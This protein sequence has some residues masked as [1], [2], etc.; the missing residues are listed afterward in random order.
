MGGIVSPDLDKKVAGLCLLVV[1]SV[2]LTLRLYGI[3]WDEGFDW[4][5]HPDERAILS[6]VDS[7]APP[8]I[9]DLRVLLDANESPWNPR[10]FPYGS[11]PLYLLKAVKLTHGLLPGTDLTDL[12]VA[13]RM[14]S[15]LADVATVAVVFAVGSAAYSRRVGLVAAALVA[16]A[17]IHIQL[18]HF[19]AADT[20]LALFAVLTMYYLVRVARHGRL[21]DSALAGLFVGLGLATKISLAPILGPFVVAHLM[22]GLGPLMGSS[23]RSVLLT[24]KVET[25]V[26]GLLIGVLVA[27]AAFLISQPYTLLDWGRFYGDVIEQSEMV[28]RIRDYPYTRQYVD[29]TPYVYQIRQLATWGLGWPLGILAWIGTLYV[30]IRGLRPFYGLIYLAV[31][32]ALPV[33][34]LLMSNSIAGVIVSATIALATLV[35]TLPMRREDSRS[36]VLLLAWVVPY[37]LITGSFEVKFLRYMLPITP[38]LILFGA[39]LAFSLWELTQRTRDTTSGVFVQGIVIGLFAVVLGGSAFYGVSYLS[40]YNDPHPAVQASDWINDNARESSIILKEHWDEGLPA[41]SQYQIKELPLYDSD[42]PAKLSLVAASLAAADYLVLF[43]NRLYGTIPRLHE[44]YPISLEYYRLLFTGELG[45][46]LAAQFSSYPELFGV[47]FVDETFARQNLPNPEALAITDVSAVS[48][49]LGFADESFSVYDHP[50]VLVFR[51][52]LNLDPEV[53]SARIFD[54]S[55]GF[56]EHPVPLKRP[57]LRVRGLMLSEDAANAQMAGGTWTDIVNPDSWTSRLPVLAWLIVVEGFAVLAFPIAFMVFRPL[58]DRGWLFS[59]ALGLMLVG[60]VVWLVTSLHWMTFSK[61]SVSVGVIVL[62]LLS[63][64]VLASQRDAI[65][66]FLVR[67]WRI[68]A[69]GEAIFLMAFLAFVMMR[70]ANPDLWHPFR[71]GE[72]PMDFAYLNAVLRSSY[73]PPYDPWF[74][75][76]YINYYYWGQFLVATLVHATGIV[77]AVAVNLAVPM[78]FSLTAA[79]AFSLVYNLAEGTRQRLA[80]RSSPEGRAS[81]RSP[82]LAGVAALLFVAVL[83]NLDGSLQVVQGAWRALVQGLPW[84]EFDFWRSSRMMA[85]DPPGHEITEFPFFTFLFGDLHAHM[86]AL[87][88]TLLALGLSAAIVAQRA[89]GA[90]SA[91]NGPRSEAVR[92]AILGLTVGALRLLNTWD[93]PT[94]LLIAAGSIILAELIRQGGIGLSMAS[95]TGLKVGLMFIIGYV[96]FLPYHTSYETFFN[97][98]EPTTNTTD[99]RQFLAISGLFVFIIGSYYTRTLWSSLA[100]ISSRIR[101]LAL[102]LVDS[103]SAD[104]NQDVPVGSFRVGVGLVLTLMGAG[105]IMAY[106]IIGL[107]SGVV[108][109]TIVF[110]A[111]ALLAVVIVA[112]RAV[113]HLQ[114]ESGSVGFV[115]MLVAVALAL[116]LGLDFLRVEGDIDRMNSVFKFYLQVWVLMALSAAYL[117]WRLLQDPIWR[118]WRRWDGVRWAW[119]GVLVALL[120]SASVYP[121]L[122]T[123]DRLRDR[124]DGTSNGLTLDGE[125]YIDGTIYHDEKGEVDLAADFEGIEWL[126]QN[127]EG[128]PVVLEANTPTYR[129][130]GRVS[131][132]TGM[133]SVVGWEW[134]QEQQR[135]GYKEE[136]DQRIRDVADIYKTEDINLAISL[137]SKYNV[138]YVYIGQIE[139]LYHP[140]RG[141]EKFDNGMAEYLEP[142]FTSEAVTI[143]RV[144]AKKM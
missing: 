90:D 34:V 13:G 137:L 56:P 63:L 52:F 88:F 116:V 22:Y 144:R 50:K 39:R 120:V 58:A 37:L 108:G 122:G 57:G 134:H 25:A 41:L 17:V 133:P 60:L 24:V 81:I 115:S 16:F 85:P 40:V 83:G 55:E 86:M 127:V 46:E 76:G 27:T 42:T 6:K 67:N 121:V 10:W 30:A 47:A 95:R 23:G 119:V 18:S 131:I 101:H 126:R 82:V 132:Y 1:V 140:G 49:N 111:L 68:I 128:S 12:R 97:S 114:S 129:W 106:L 45:Y 110:A 117:L 9:S 84:G 143:Y 21:Q 99:L 109:T 87:P 66:S 91:G 92:I 4:T 2:A 70:A 28:R 14:I 105:L 123:P 135:W 124:F 5:P 74:A 73:M 79:G 15:A 3:S 136:V 72:K 69:I 53:M 98:L 107:A 142:V 78:F 130:G 65:K 80:Q 7:L 26:R 112:Y 33:S 100:T 38:F 61:G 93:Y 11:F 118:A 138:S 102:L 141:L 104:R 31:G 139:R 89:S 36:D 54:A 96:V 75:G 35:A 125:N 51:N 19:F 48:L 43:S 32:W 20:L 29:T 44:R 8:D 62:L 77:P 94:Y 71:G 113:S 59:K 103:V 64:G